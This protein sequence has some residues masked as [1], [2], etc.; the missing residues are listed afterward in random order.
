MKTFNKYFAFLVMVS[1]L[2][3][4]H[5]TAQNL[6]VPYETFRSLDNYYILPA[7]VYL[8]SN[9]I[10]ASIDGELIQVNTLCADEAG[11]FISYGEIAAKLTRCPF[12]S[13]WHTQDKGHPKCSGFPE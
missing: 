3:A 2:F 6:E 11:I 8:A 5:F 10:Y 13:H 12:C 9:G 7:G 4:P 1:V